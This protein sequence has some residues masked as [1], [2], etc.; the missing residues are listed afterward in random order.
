MI[1]Y[2][3]THARS[4][5]DRFAFSSSSIVSYCHFDMRQHNS[6]NEALESESSKKIGRRD[7]SKKKL[8]SRSHNTLFEYSQLITSCLLRQS[9]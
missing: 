3:A 4:T 8:M 5:R 2:L 1:F 9:G 7:K 6:V